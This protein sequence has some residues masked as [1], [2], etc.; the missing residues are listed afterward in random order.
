MWNIEDQDH[1][2]HRLKNRNVM[3]RFFWP[4]AYNVFPYTVT[5]KQD[6]TSC[7]A[8]LVLSI[9]MKFFILLELV[10]I[11]AMTA[12]YLLNQV[13]PAEPLNIALGGALFIKNIHRKYE[14]KSNYVCLH[15]IQ[16]L[17]RTVPEV[18]NL[19]QV[20]GQGF[21]HFRYCGQNSGSC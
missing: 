1:H 5:S 21:L 2:L 10:R 16:K 3:F 18:L 4:F 19:Q 14:M 17:L 9:F 20:M 13:E 6:T 11:C 8:H 15:V 7:F 12:F